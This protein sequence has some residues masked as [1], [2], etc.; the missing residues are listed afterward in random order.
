M[1]LRHERHIR[2]VGALSLAALLAGCGGGAPYVLS[3][4]R[5]HQKGMVEVCYDGK[6]APQDQALT[7]QKQALK[8]A[9]GICSQYDRMATLQLV[10]ENQCNW[11]TPDIALYYCVARPGEHPRPLVP[12]KA[13]L[14]GGLSGNQNSGSN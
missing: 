5:L 10:Q 11:T 8:L 2:A 12:Q 7:P 13:P 3:D 9:D 6:S 1:G 14:R 4:Y